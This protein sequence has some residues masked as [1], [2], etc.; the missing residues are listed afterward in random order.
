MRSEKM[1]PERKLE[2]IQ[3]V[4]QRWEEDEMSDLIA[5]EDIGRA[6]SENVVVANQNSETHHKNELKKN[7]MEKKPVET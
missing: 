7:G 2:E 3:Y 1:T 5:L 4:I 6:S